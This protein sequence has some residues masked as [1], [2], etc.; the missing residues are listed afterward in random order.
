MMMLMIPV[1]LILTVSHIVFVNSGDSIRFLVYRQFLS[2]QV[3]GHSDDFASSTGLLGD[4]HTGAMVA[5]DGVTV[6]EST[7][8]Y[9]AEWQVGADEPQLSQ[10]CCDPSAS[11]VLPEEALPSMTA[12]RLRASTALEKAA[13]KACAHKSPK[14]FE[15]CIFDILAT[16][17]VSM[18]GAW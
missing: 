11:C 18:A 13:A 7:N 8:E 10:E 6:M 3:T 5:R 4:Y 2:V 16:G 15:F 14:D 17:D 9:G 12:H 1:H